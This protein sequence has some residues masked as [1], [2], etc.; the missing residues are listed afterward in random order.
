MAYNVLIVDDSGTTRR[1]IEKTLK[2]SGLP[3]G[4]ITHAENGREGLDQIREKWLDLVITDINMPVMNG[5]EMLE[6]LARDELLKSL[7]VL[8]ISTEG[9]QARIDGLRALGVRGF[10]RKPFQP[11]QIKQMIEEILGGGDAA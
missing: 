6:D 7:P 1:V 3:L 10:L 9:G 8:V 5:V 2:L 4:E 11:E